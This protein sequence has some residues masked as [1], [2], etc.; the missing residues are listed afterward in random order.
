MNHLSEAELVEHYYGESKPPVARHL[1]MCAQCTSAFEGMCAE[2]CDVETIELPPRDAGYGGR[3]WAVLEP[4][5][6]AYPAR[7]RAWSR[8]AL[9]LALSSAAACVLL[10]GTAFYAGRFWEHREEPH[11]VVAKAPQ[12]EPRQVVV[13]VLSDHLDRSERLLV[14]FKHADAEDSE[15]ISPI[16]D[17]ARSLLSANLKCQEEAEKMGDASLT[18]ALDHLNRLLTELASQPEGIDAAAITRLQ[19]EMNQDGLLFEV[20]VLRSRIPNREHKGTNGLKGAAV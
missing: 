20:R 9:W 14:E 12:P 4:R 11:N 5:L 17:E 3:V 8:P 2:L 16:R 13:V 7:K 10:A 1:G 6:S 19:N 15:T 18:K